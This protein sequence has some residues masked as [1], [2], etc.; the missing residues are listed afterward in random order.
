[1]AEAKIKIAIFSTIIF[2]FL[3][4]FTFSVK[5]ELDY[6]N[7]RSKVIS[8]IDK[9]L[10]YNLKNE[11]NIFHAKFTGMFE[12]QFENKETKINITVN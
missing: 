9:S 4:L 10:A 6:N 7:S 3:L 5:N 12:A 1:M 2:T 11:K 8:K